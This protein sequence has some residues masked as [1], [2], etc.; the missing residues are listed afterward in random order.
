MKK[1]DLQILCF[2]SDVKGNVEYKA[3]ELLIN[4]FIYLIKCLIYG[5]FYP[6]VNSIYFLQD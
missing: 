2:I 3:L 6:T 5:S 1:H 4:C